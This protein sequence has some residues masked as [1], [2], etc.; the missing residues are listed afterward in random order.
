MNAK[1]NANKK[2]V[3]PKQKLRTH[4]ARDS[5][6][7]DLQYQNQAHC[8]NLTNFYIVY[9]VNLEILRLLQALKQLLWEQ[10]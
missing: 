9:N 10:L 1:D 8:V 6:I 4:T 3:N 7:T 5:E 2:K